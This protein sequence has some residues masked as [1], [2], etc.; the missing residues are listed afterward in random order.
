VDRVFDAGAI[1]RTHV[2]RPTWHFVLP[3]DIRWLLELSAARIRRGLAGRYR[4]LEIDE[5]VVARAQ[6][7]LVAA[8]GGG[9]QLTRSELQDKFHSAGL[10]PEGQRLPHLLMRAELDGLITSG[11]RRGKQFTYA[12]LEER[13]PKAQPLERPEAVAE[14]TRRY[15]RSHGPAQLQDFVWWSG[16]TVAEARSG[17]AQAR[18]DLDHELIAGK[19]Y[20]SEGRAEPDRGRA[21]PAHLLPNFDEYTVG[22]RDRAA[23]LPAGPFDPAHLSFGSILSNV[24]LVGGRVC[25]AWRRLQTRA[26][27][28]VEVRLFNRL[29]DAELEAVQQAG[30]KLSRFMERPVHLAWTSAQ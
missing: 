18:P 11:A 22:Y 26:G 30:E 9:I 19:D 15:F 4:R 25:G 7:T 10:R 13:V 27:V 14:L 29:R 2:M 3:G 16:L 1:L 24:V 17:L 28:R 21:A 5:E 20:W 23:A 6:S 8:L 12:L